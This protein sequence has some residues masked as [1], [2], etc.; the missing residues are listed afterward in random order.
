MDLEMLTYDYASYNDLVEQLAIT[1]DDSGYQFDTVLA[2]ARG[3]VPLGDAFSRIFN[4]PLAILAAS[5]YELGDT[6]SDDV[7]IADHITCAKP[8][9]KTIL[10]VDDMVDSGKTVRKVVRMLQQRYP[11][12]T[13]K[14]AVLWWKD[15]S[16]IKPEFYG[17][18]IVGNPWIIQPFERFDSLPIET[19][20]QQHNK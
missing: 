11:D 12:A 18:H 20:R 1:I 5:S 15:H 6:H 14:V 8:I 2:L 16:V 13:I 4:K 7:D 10:V 19:I 3:G 9:G 17:M